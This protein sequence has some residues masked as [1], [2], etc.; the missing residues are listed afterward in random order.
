MDKWVFSPEVLIDTHIDHT[1]VSCPY[2]IWDKKLS[3]FGLLFDALWQFLVFAYLWNTQA[4]NNTC[5]AD[6]L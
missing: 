2:A 4:Q 6:A 3:S 5:I 1:I